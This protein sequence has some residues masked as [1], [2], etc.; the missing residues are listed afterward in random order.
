LVNVFSHAGDLT[1]YVCEVV[2]ALIGFLLNFS[3]DVVQGY[4]NGIANLVLKQF[5]NVT[6]SGYV[7]LTIRLYFFSHR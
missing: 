3:S 2:L 1:G 5:T 7:C 4:N 6:I